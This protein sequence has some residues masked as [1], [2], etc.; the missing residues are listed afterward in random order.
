MSTDLPPASIS[1]QHGWEWN[2]LQAKQDP[3]DSPSSSAHTSGGLSKPHG[4]RRPSSSTR[5]GT[6]THRGTET[7][8]HHIDA[9][10]GDF[11][12]ELDRTQRRLQHVIDHYERL[13]A[14]KNRQLQTQENASTRRVPPLLSSLF[15]YIDPR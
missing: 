12:A 4:N 10:S 6:D 8:P 5:R 7:R 15:E 1:G 3:P 11:A 13:L 2:E 14:K 9:A